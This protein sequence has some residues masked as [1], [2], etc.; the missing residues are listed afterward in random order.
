MKTNTYRKQKGASMIEIVVTIV[1]VAVGLLGVAS[2]QANT[3]KYLKIANLRSEA[4]QS[5]YDLSE[6]MRANGRGVKDPNTGA[7]SYVYTTP[8]AT[9]VASLP[10]PPT[11]AVAV[12]TPAEVAA[13]DVNEWLRVLANKLYGGAGYIVQNGNDYDVIVM[14]K[15]LNLTAVDPAC[16][17]GTPPAPGVGVRCVTVRFTP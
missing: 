13:R 12:C 17:V 16:P 11:C 7:T 6:R 9:T 14:W 3:M 4:T 5:A 15:E 8:Y 10:A 1:I 2:L